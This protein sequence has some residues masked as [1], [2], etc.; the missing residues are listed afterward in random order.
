[1]GIDSGGHIVVCRGGRFFE[2][3]DYF[4]CFHQRAA[5]IDQTKWEN[6]FFRLRMGKVQAQREA[7]FSKSDFS[8]LLGY[9]VF[10]YASVNPCLRIFLDFNLSPHSKLLLKP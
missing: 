7:Y 1:M 2:G 8:R 5:I 9:E 10:S 3:D 4:K 6:I